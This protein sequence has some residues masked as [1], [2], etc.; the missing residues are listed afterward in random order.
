MSKRKPAPEKVKAAPP[1]GGGVSQFWPPG[2]YARIAGPL[3][4]GAAIIIGFFM[5]GGAWASFA[6]L[7]GGAV[8]PGVVSPL[9]SKRV[10]Q[11]LEGGIVEALHVREGQTVRAGDPLVSLATTRAKAG[12][13]VLLERRRSLLGARARLE[14]EQAGTSAVSFP[15][16][17]TA[18]HSAESRAVLDT[19]QRMFDEHRLSFA[20]QMEVAR[21]RARQL[22]EQIIGL[23]GVL[24][25]DDKAVQALT[26]QLNRL[27]RVDEAFMP[28][29]RVLELQRELAERTGQRTRNQAD[30]SRSR[31]ALIEAKAQVR[32]LQ[33]QNQS[34]IAEG[35]DQVRRELVEV[36]NELAASRDVL[37]RT[38]ITAPVDGVVLNKRISTVGGVLA[39]GQPILEIVPLKELLVIEARV[40]PVDIDIV[41]PG[42]EAQIRLSAFSELNLPQIHGVVRRISAD[43][44]VDEKSGHSFYVAEVEAPASELE[45][46]KRTSPSLKLVPG[47]PAEVLIVTGKRTLVEY[48]TEPMLRRFHRALREA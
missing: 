26:E 6:R 11:H 28:R 33:G 46:L 14:A 43:A 15:E 45:R 3:H 10:V 24:Q 39:P 23:E 41:R 32:A 44:I 22:E 16:D 21:S 30:L 2:L 25:S 42:L 29:T 37:D 5:V 12:L 9:N 34:E 4:V 8:A 18:D 38:V 1:S 13:D 17:L 20:A 47:M 31:Q 35:L 48:L 40:S 19:Q 27:S 7:E 36:E